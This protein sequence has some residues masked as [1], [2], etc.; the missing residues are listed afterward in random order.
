MKLLI[1]KWHKEEMTV[2]CQSVN[3]AACI[4]LTSLLSGVEYDVNWP[5][6]ARQRDFLIGNITGVAATSAGR[7]ILLHRGSYRFRHGDFR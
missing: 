6:I 2:V 3:C 5:S 7:I 4:G 1:S